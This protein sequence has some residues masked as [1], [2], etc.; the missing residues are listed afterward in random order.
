ML[1][2]NINENEVL[3]TYTE[4]EE[5]QDYKAA[6]ESN[7][8][9]NFRMLRERAERAE[10]DK[11]EL[12]RFI[13][14]QNNQKIDSQDEDF[15]VEDEDFVSGKSYKKSL[16]EIK[17]QLAES[18]RSLNEFRTQTSE[19]VAKARLT[20]EYPNFNKV[21]TA[22]NIKKLQAQ[23]PAVYQALLSGSDTYATGKAAYEVLEKF[24][25]G[26]YDLEDKKILENQ[27]KPKAAASVPNRTEGALHAFEPGHRM[28]LT[29]EQ[30]EAIIKQSRMYQKMR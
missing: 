30:K 15:G 24:N 22:E 21:V 11:E 17:K 12:T 7:K 5:Q 14:Q 10:R 6:T 1:D 19:E 18:Q 29:K 28:F 3:E 4:T 9:Y 8:E 27:L 23:S 13:Q 2:E 16:K 26:R 20:Q 25:I